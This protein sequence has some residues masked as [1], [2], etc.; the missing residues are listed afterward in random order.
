M[1]CPFCQT[2]DSK[3]IDSRMIREGLAI[4]R[5]RLCGDCGNRFTTYEQIGDNPVMVIKKDSSRVPFER[6][7]I[8]IG[9][10]KAC[11]KRP[12]STETIEAIAAKIE[13]RITRA[14]EPEVSS[15]RIGELVMEEL[16]SL[17]QVAY[18]RFASVYREF[19]DVTDFE[20]EIR[21]M[22]VE[23]RESE[24]ASLLGDGPSS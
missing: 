22:L 2:P 1:K 14:G 20:D 12:V 5:R 21:P 6:E 13:G 9:L 23:R 11:Y 18:V 19:K 10:E 8:R 4:R 16:R 15:A 3:V 7:K 17:D 24:L